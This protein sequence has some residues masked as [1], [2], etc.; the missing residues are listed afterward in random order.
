MNITSTTQ[1]QYP[2]A[3]ARTQDASSYEEVAQ[4]K[5]LTRHEELLAMNYDNMSE[6][7][8]R[9]L[10]YWHGMR[11][12][13]FLDEEGNEALNKALEGKTDAEKSQIKSVLELSFMTSVKVDHTNQTVNREKFDSIDTSK[14]ATV[15]R[16]DKFIVDFEKSGSEDKIGLIDTINKF[17]N[18]YK[19]DN[20]LTNIKNQE[21]SVIDKFL[22][23]LY[24]KNSSNLRSAI[25]KDEI[26]NK[27]NEYAQLMMEENGDTPKSELDASKI[28]NEYKR[29]LLQEYKDTL[30]SAKNEKITP[31]QEAIIKVLLDENKKETSSLEKLIATTDV[32]KLSDAKELDSKY[33]DN[34]IPTVEELLD[35]EGMAFLNGLIEGMSEK[36]ANAVKLMFSFQLSIKNVTFTNGQLNIERETGRLDSQSILNK[37]EMLSK[38]KNRGGYLA[39][40]TTKIINELKDFYTDK[41]QNNTSNKNQE[42]HIQNNITDIDAYKLPTLDDK[43]NTMLNDLLLGKSDSE[44]TNAKMWLD[45]LLLPNNIVNFDENGSNYTYASGDSLGEKLDYIAQEAKRDSYASQEFLSL[46]TKLSENYTT[47]TE[48]IQANYYMQNLDEKGN[49]IINKILEGRTETEKFAIKGILDRQL[50]FKHT[51]AYAMAVDAFNEYNKSDIG[52]S[53]Q[54]NGFKNKEILLD[55]LDEFIERQSNGIDNLG[56]LEIAKQLRN[57]YM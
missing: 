9:E 13:S 36:N 7:E 30:E 42:N 50:N 39:D 3:N 33:K 43:A 46:I 48:S 34:A 25:A 41:V 32:N 22:E 17:L 31:Q 21:D 15:D 16:F 52:V 38:N 49:E 12:V 26:E 45:F 6:A 11:S 44:K 24:S 53:I 8:R 56:I 20:S 37:L 5:Q 47:K 2:T 28:L 29:E 19:H 40:V 1:T 4:K 57:E 27:V 14:S 35:K 51:E 10:S 23:D 55:N 54:Q 18:I